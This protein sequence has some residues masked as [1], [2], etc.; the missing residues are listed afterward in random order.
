MHGKFAWYE[1]VTTDVEA[2]GAF[3][4]AVVGWKAQ[5]AGEGSDYTLFCGEAGGVAGMLPLAHTTR[6]ASAGPIWMGYIDV[7]NAEA[8]LEALVAA[9]GTVHRPIETIPGMLRFAV[10]AD[11]QGVAFVIFTPDPAMAGAPPPNPR[12]PKGFGWSELVTTDWEAA[13]AFYSGLFGWEKGQ[14]M[15]M[16]P[17]GVYQLFKVGGGPDIGGMMN[18]PPQNPGP[19]L[20]AHYINVDAIGAAVQRLEAAGGRVVNGPH[21]VPGPMYVVQGVDPQGALFSLLSEKP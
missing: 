15:D 17:M 3:Y 10:V 21:E 19:P 5:S 7:D 14:G 8:T 2:A 16:G 11:P 13:F 1:L 4:E 6:P 20:W 12:A 9:G 18:K